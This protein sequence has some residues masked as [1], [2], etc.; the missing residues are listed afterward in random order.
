EAQ[1]MPAESVRLQWKSTVLAHI[2]RIRIYDAN[3]YFALEKLLRYSTDTFC[4]S[5]GQQSSTESIVHFLAGGVH[6]PSICPYF[7]VYIYYEGLKSNKTY[8]KNSK[9]RSGLRNPDLFVS[10]L[11]ALIKISNPLRSFS[12]KD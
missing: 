3:I 9:K 7:A 12:I 8:E 4:T 2:Q 11:E 6:Q 5:R 1:A 10:Y